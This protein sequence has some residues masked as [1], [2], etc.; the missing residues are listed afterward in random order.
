MKIK[1]LIFK[2]GSVICSF[3]FLTAIQSLDQMCGG[4]FYQP[5]VPCSLEKYRNDR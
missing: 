4:S 2:A 1:N 3:A 5:E